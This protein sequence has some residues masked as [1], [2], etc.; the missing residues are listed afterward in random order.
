MVSILVAALLLK[1]QGF[2]PTAIFMKNWEE[3]DTVY[4][5]SAA[6]DIEDA[7]AVCDKIGINLNR[8]LQD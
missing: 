7:K 4:H 3:D 1:Q 2:N 5:C 8:I 6:P